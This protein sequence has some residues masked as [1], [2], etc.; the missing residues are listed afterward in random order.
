ML[1]KC[2]SFFSFIVTLENSRK[3]SPPTSGELLF[4][5]K[6][7]VFRAPFHMV[8]TFFNSISIIAG[9]CFCIRLLYYFTIWIF[10]T[11]HSPSNPLAELNEANFLC[12]VLFTL[13]SD[14]AALDFTIYIGINLIRTFTT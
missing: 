12:V 10:K 1:W 4:L 3:K 8:E 13:H 9:S 5:G 14:G 7:D 6:R 2:A 11:S